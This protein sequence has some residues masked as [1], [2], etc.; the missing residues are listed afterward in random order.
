M[1]RT[2]KRTAEEVA[3]RLSKKNSWLRKEIE[4]F[5]RMWQDIDFG[6]EKIY[7]KI[8]DGTDESYYYLCTGSLIIW[9]KIGDEYFDSDDN[10]SPWSV[11]I[12]QVREM[13]HNLPEAIKEINE[14]AEDLASTKYKMF[15]YNREKI[16]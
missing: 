12:A 5:F 15:E 11:D 1:K 8:A 16:K 4:D 10:L 7:S 3:E 9:A 13:A 14:Q 6:G 2:K